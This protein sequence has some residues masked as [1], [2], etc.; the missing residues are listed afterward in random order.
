MS[1]EIDFFGERSYFSHKKIANGLVDRSNPYNFYQA[2]DA[3]YNNK[4]LAFISDSEVFENG[5]FIAITDDGYIGLYTKG[6]SLFNNGKNIRIN[7]DKIDYKPLMLTVDIFSYNWYPINK[8]E[9]HELE[10]K[11][12]LDFNDSDCIDI[13]GCSFSELDNVSRYDFL[14][15]KL[16]EV[17]DMEEEPDFIIDGYDYSA[18]K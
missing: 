16:E 15:K 17:M 12:D 6:A 8:D 14:M 1:F 18:Y 4:K 3:L 9:M 13:Y 10:I 5:D 2:L 7:K 11:Y